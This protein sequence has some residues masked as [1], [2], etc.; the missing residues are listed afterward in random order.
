MDR[1]SIRW[2]RLESRFETDY[3]LATKARAGWTDKSGIFEFTRD[4]L[5]EAKEGFDFHRVLDV[6]AQNGA[7]LIPKNGKLPIANG[8]ELGSRRTWTNRMYAG[9]LPRI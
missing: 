4:E 3:N 9:L 8:H 2:W 6:L 5:R 1:S 7:L